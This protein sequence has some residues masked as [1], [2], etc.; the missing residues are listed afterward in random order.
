MRIVT[1]VSAFDQHLAPK[2]CE[3]IQHL[4]CGRNHELHLVFPR[5]AEVAANTIYEGMV[6]DKP[7]KGKFI[8][9]GPDKQPQFVPVQ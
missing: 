5:S 4:D 6:G 2:W 7:M 3:V 1:P 9:Y 8:G